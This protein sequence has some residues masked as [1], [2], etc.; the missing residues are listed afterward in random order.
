MLAGVLLVLTS[1]LL[2]VFAWERRSLMVMVA[3]WAVNLLTLQYAMVSYA[4]A[5]DA[6]SRLQYYWHTVMYLEYALAMA[7]FALTIAIAGVL[8][9]QRREERLRRIVEPP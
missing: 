8:V 4:D 3:S 5:V 6:G 9:T 7:N 1:I 2:P